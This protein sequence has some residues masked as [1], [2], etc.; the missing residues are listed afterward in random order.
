MMESL[1]Y[2]YAQQSIN[3]TSEANFDIIWPC[4]FSITYY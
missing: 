1:K 3:K 2:S 4:A